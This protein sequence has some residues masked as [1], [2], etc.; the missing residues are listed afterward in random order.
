M[1]DFTLP[2][3]PPDFVPNFLTQPQPIN[4]DTQITELL[5]QYRVPQVMINDDTRGDHFPK[6]D[7]NAYNF[8]DELHDSLNN[9]AQNP[10]RGETLSREQWVECAA[11][12]SHSI[13]TGLVNNAQGMG[14]VSFRNDLPLESRTHLVELAKNIE[15]I[16]RF[17]Q[18]PYDE[19]VTTNYCHKCLTA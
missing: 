14:A 10:D 7:A 15:R 4:N 11:L 5:D 17:F 16:N 3:L 1:G 6:V 8:L 2:S 9:L 13:V 18:L 19:H 12:Y